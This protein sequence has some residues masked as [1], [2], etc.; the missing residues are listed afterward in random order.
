M[1]I[2]ELIAAA[3]EIHKEYGDIEVVFG[4]CN[5]MHTARGIDPLIVDNLEERYLEEICPEDNYDERPIN[6]AVVYA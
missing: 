4:D 2:L 5:K 1:K 6:A 3:I